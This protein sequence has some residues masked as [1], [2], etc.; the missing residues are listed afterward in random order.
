MVACRNAAFRV[1]LLSAKLLAS[2]QD[3][4]THNEWILKEKCLSAGS[5]MGGG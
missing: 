5:C 2:A 4:L 3:E 1:A